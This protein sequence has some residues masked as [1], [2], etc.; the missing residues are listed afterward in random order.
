MSRRKRNKLSAD[1][2]QDGR[3]VLD[4]F[5]LIDM[6]KL[7]ATADLK[8]LGEKI[9]PLLRVPP[10]RTDA[11]FVEREAKNTPPAAIRPDANQT[12][13]DL[14]RWWAVRKAHAGLSW[15]KAYQAA[16]N[17]TQEYGP[18]FAGSEWAMKRSH[19]AIQRLRKRPG[20]RKQS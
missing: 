9:L 18:P 19:N 8:R 4:E 13:V 17:K 15:P 6:D 5:D 7:M 14:V 3:R 12:S 1:G 2:I 20:Q 10:P 11:W 16:S